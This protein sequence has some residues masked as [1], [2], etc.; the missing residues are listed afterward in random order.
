MHGR[1]QLTDRLGRRW[2]GH[3]RQ[4]CFHSRGQAALVKESA[5]Q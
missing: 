5:T 4:G 2:D 3:Y 1:G